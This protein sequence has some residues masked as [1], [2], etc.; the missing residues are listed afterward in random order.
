MDNEIEKMVALYNRAEMQQE[1]RLRRIYE[2]IRQ[3]KGFRRVKFGISEVWSNCWAL[4][5]ADVDTMVKRICHPITEV[6]SGGE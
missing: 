6:N 5:P 4:L 2:L 3:R 1:A